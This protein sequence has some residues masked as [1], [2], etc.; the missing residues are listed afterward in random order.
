MRK[1]LRKNNEKRLLFTGIV[2][3]FGTK[4]NWHGF[5]EKTILFKDVKYESGDLA[6]DH[7]WFTVGKTIASLELKE[8]DRISFEARIGRYMKGYVNYR[9]C[10]DESIPDYKL[11]RPTKFKKI[12]SDEA[13][14]EKSKI[15]NEGP[16]RYVSFKNVVYDLK[17]G[18]T[19][20]IEPIP[21][22]DN[23][24]CENLIE[25]GVE[26]FLIST[27]GELMKDNINQETLNNFDIFLSN[28]LDSLRRLT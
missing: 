1:E 8:G 7:I 11:N 18:N 28:Y 23:S 17:N 6:T 21:C 2:G 14:I 24:T 27:E 19:L 3:C 4:K 22:G 26:K 20:T 5:P 13:S 16:I 10:I 15:M 9:E 25:M 12:I